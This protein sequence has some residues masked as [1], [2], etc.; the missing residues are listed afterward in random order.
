MLMAYYLYLACASAN[1]FLAEGDVVYTAV[2][3]NY[4]G[5]K[6]GTAMVMGGLE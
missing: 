4:A 6:S 2:A 3:N 1:G 5:N